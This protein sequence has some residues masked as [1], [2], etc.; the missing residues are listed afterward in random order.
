MFKLRDANAYLGDVTPYPTTFAPVGQGVGVGNAEGQR[1]SPPPLDDIYGPMFG[2]YGGVVQRTMMTQQPTSDYR[3]GGASP[4][5]A[6]AGSGNPR[7]VINGLTGNGAYLNK[8]WPTL[9]TLTDLQAMAKN[10]GG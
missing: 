7:V 1:W 8:G 2:P 10:N 3:P 4:D 6:A 9:Q 5:G